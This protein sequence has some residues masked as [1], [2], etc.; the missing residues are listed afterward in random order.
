MHQINLG[1]VRPKSTSVD[2]LFEFCV[3]QA[4]DKHLLSTPHLHN[5]WAN[6]LFGFEK[7][8]D[9]RVDYMSKIKQEYTTYFTAE[10]RRSPK[11][12]FEE[13]KLKRDFP[14]MFGIEDES[15]SEV[16]TIN[17]WIK[18][19]IKAVN[20]EIMEEKDPH[21]I[22]IFRGGP[23]DLIQHKESNYIYRV[24]LDLEE[25]QEPHFRE[26]DPFFLK[27][28]DKKFNCEAI[29]Y[30]FEQGKLSF[31]ANRMIYS[32]KYCTIISDSSFIQEGLR[33]KLSEISRTEID[34]D[35]PF[36]KFY[37]EDT[38]EPKKVYHKEVSLKFKE[39]LDESQ[40]E[41]FE[42]AL[43]H[44]LTF[45]WGPPGTGKSYTLASIIYALYKLGEDRT[46]VCCL[47]NVAVD[48][49]LCKVLDR[50][51]DE[52]EKVELGQFYRAGRTLDKRII[53]TDFLFPKDSKT[54]QLRNTIKSKMEKIQHLKKLGRQKSDEAITLKAESKE[55]REQLKNHTEHLVRSS[56]I[57]FSTISNF[58]LT[59]TLNEST[60]DNLIVDEASMLS[61]PS[62]I[63]LASKITKRL[64]LVGDFQQ[65]SPISLVKSKI[66]TDSVF[67]LSDINIG[68][69]DHPAMYQL[70]NQ[71]RSN[72]EIV[73]L[74]N[75][76]FYKGKLVS[77][78]EGSSKIISEAPYAG[79]A[80]VLRNI[81]SGAVKYTKGGTRQN[82]KFAESIID[83]LDDFYDN[84]PDGSF[85]IGV[86]TPYK[87]EVALLRALK[88]ERKYAE[89]FD[90][91]IK[92]GTIHTFQ[93]SECDVII[94]DMVDC[95]QLESGKASRSIGRL[96][97]GKDGERLLNVA[98]SR[99]KHKLIVV[100]DQN[101]IKNI[102][103]N[104]VTDRTRCVFRDLSRYSV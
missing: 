60:F 27:V 40:K 30:D 12:S 49:L 22:E 35:Y 52:K 73:D 17:D 15:D 14:E 55:L 23:I 79:R 28:Y 76:T 20:H 58:V 64:I 67:E 97:A 5:Q 99:A 96:Y 47:S 65:L 39:G 93:G 1:L 42:A 16:E 46:A 29:D 62:L 54:I 3:H 24:K 51:Q 4:I 2:D 91:R 45:I 81:S 18:G 41:A 7:S 36:T 94:F 34:E 50:I 19:C 8:S 25:G 31:T 26:S 21:N 84:D 98:L 6:L 48:Q 75:D 53:A 104:T 89:S 95:A 69:T 101:Y 11:Y 82:K 59:P 37:F 74:F 44:D 87:G 88:M 77:K 9:V 66:L 13:E 70:L 71:R 33:D 10:S 78:I 85:T 90:S 86:I 72:K 92:I 83:I 32:A 57:V 38:N 63:A 80:V 102:P 100:C 61:A 68:Y 56:K 43:D 103:G